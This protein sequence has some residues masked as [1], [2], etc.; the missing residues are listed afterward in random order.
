MSGLE[1]RA[2]HG[3]AS[4]FGQLIRAW[5]DDL[6]GV[7]WSIVRSAVDTDDVTQRSYEK[8]FRTIESFR[9]DAS[10]KTW[11]HS[12][13]YRAALDH[14]RYEQRRHHE[15]TAALTHTPSAESP[16]EQALHKV[17]LATALEQLDPPVRALLMLTA[18]LGYTFDETAEIVGMERGTVASKVGR[19][20]RALRNTENER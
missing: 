10:L 16:S 8:A 15:S 2:R 18:G 6:R 11:L 3:D 17:E 20:K 19:A 7:V 12:I 13:C 1:A 5:D 4:A 9:G 14:Q